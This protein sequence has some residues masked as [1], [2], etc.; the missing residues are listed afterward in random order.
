MAGRERRDLR[1]QMHRGGRRWWWW[2]ARNSGEK[3]ACLLP[4]RL[5]SRN[6]PAGRKKGRREHEVGRG[7]AESGRPD[8][9]NR[10]EAG[11]GWLARRGAPVRPSS[12]SSSSS[13]PHQPP[14]CARRATCRAR[15]LG[16]PGPRASARRA[17]WTGR[18]PW[19]WGAAGWSGQWRR[20]SD[21]ILIFRL[22]RAGAGRGGVGR[23]ASAD[24]IP[25]VPRPR[26][27]GT[28]RRPRGVAWRDGRG[29]GTETRLRRGVAG[30][31]EA[32][33]DADH[34]EIH[35]ANERSAPG[36]GGFC[37][38]V[39]LD[40]TGGGKGKSVRR[41]WSPLPAHAEGGSG[42][43]RFSTATSGPRAA[44]RRAGARGSA[45]VGSDL[46]PRHA[47]PHPHLAF[48]FHLPA[49]GGAVERAWQRRGTAS[50][51]FFV[52]SPGLAAR[53]LP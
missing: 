9:R 46:H 34:G 27:D 36:S 21:R 4:P 12:S 13:F 32:D 5:M 24:R 26:A 30:V 17:P 42:C 37:W 3:G 41:A 51:L 47:P 15:Q 25:P 39:A 49:V 43:P 29:V 38:V 50:F 45:A 2:W 7:A 35:I 48:G 8:H 19:P 40:C 28:A 53:P 23:D 20:A 16:D 18:C 10:E 52:P 14:A 1:C 11:W 33:A 6:R 44:G 31:G 22:G